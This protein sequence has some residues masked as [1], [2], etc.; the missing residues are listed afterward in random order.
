MSTYSDDEK[1][2]L[3]PAEQGQ[4]PSLN[5]SRRISHIGVAALVG[6]A[7]TGWSL[8]FLTCATGY[9]E[10]GSVLSS[11][12]E[13]LSS[14]Q[15]QCMDVCFNDFNNRIVEDGIEKFVSEF[16]S[17]TIQHSQPHHGHHRVSKKR[18]VKPENDDCAVNKAHCPNPELQA[19]HDLG[20]DSKTPAVKSI[21]N[22]LEAAVELPDN[23]QEWQG[24]YENSIKSLD[25]DLADVRVI[26]E[27]QLKL[28]ILVQYEYIK[29]TYKEA[30][31]GY[32]EQVIS[33]LPM[34]WTE[35]QPSYASEGGE[36]VMAKRDLSDLGDERPEVAGPI[37]PTKS[38]PHQE[39]NTSRPRIYVEQKWK[40][41][42]P[43]N[44][45]IVMPTGIPWPPSSS[46]K[47][48]VVD[49]GDEEA[50]QSTATS[51][52]TKTL[53]TRV[54]YSSSSSSPGT[55][56]LPSSIPTLEPES[57]SP[58]PPSSSPDS[59]PNKKPK[60]SPRNMA[61]P[62]WKKPY[63]RKPR[64]KYKG[65]RPFPKWNPEHKSDRYPKESSDW[66]STEPQ[67][68]RKQF[69]PKHDYVKNQQSNPEHGGLV[70]DP[71][72]AMTRISGRP[73][74]LGAN[75]EGYRRLGLEE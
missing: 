42:V 21:I 69:G 60:L 63:W 44:P 8:L 47:Q 51:Y 70:K 36:S 58:P 62:P 71:K 35:P 74:G 3:I 16:H 23:P 45:G 33:P 24:W 30:G 68:T 22:H 54:A 43:S 34:A 18:G 55:Q 14:T 17:Y 46:K 5:R 20:Y 11:T 39:S 6:V 65:S 64:P 29:N 13:P 26:R 37:E 40:T 57:S 72:D 27:A 50:Q 28:A 59:D 2:Y 52:P 1:G 49:K 41:Q 61:K 4:M 66:F 48:L 9:N 7:V 25:K 56:V 12:A 19:L 31:P 38:I 32:E 73:F 67:P 53:H 10:G 75:E 15:Q